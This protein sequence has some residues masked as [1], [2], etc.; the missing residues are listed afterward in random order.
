[1]RKSLLIIFLPPGSSAATSMSWCRCAAY[2]SATRDEAR[3]LGAYR[4]RRRPAAAAAAM[5]PFS[6]RVSRA[7]LLMSLNRSGPARGRHRAGE[8]T[9]LMIE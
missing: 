3:L 9:K 7:Q 4:G 6:V 2:F 1:M 5:N 8:M